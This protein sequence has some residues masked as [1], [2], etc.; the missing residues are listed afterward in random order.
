[1]RF[2]LLVFKGNIVDKRNLTKNRKKI[3]RLPPTVLSAKC[4]LVM[5]PR[6]GKTRKQ[7]LCI[8]CAIVNTRKI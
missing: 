4:S 3:K 8:F 7:T 2:L 6:Y 5:L 1:M